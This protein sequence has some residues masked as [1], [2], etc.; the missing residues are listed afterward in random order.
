ML[1]QSSQRTCSNLTYSIQS[2]ND[3]EVMLFTVNTDGSKIEGYVDA[4]WSDS[5]RWKDHIDKIISHNLLVPAYVEVYFRPCPVGF[6]LS[7]D[8]SCV[9]AKALNDSVSGCFIDSFQIKRKNSYWIGVESSSNSSTSYLIHRHCPFDNC[10]SGTFLFSLEKPDAQCNQHH[11]GILCGACEPGYS[12]ILGGTECKRCTNIY[13]LLLIG[14]TVAGVG[15]IVFLS[16]TDTTVATGAFSGLLF[17]ANIIADNKTSFFPPQAA[18]SFLS[19]FIAWLNLDLGISTCFYDGLDA[20]V[21]TWLQL[22]FYVWL[23]AFIIIITCRHVS[24]MSKLCGNNIVPVLA[25]LFLLS[26]TQFYFERLTMPRLDKDLVLLFKPVVLIFFWYAVFSTIAPLSTGGVEGV[27]SLLHACNITIVKV[28][29][30]YTSV[31]SG[32]SPVPCS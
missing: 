31:H 18:N 23:L 20:Y 12:L 30:A 27:Q 19:V 29:F 4:L 32:P 9:C 22:P 21:Y 13:L 7:P 3:R 15:L 17:Y 10:K 28:H 1:V 16:L 25:T 14:F 6:E 2:P 8:Y 24:F 5:S 26:Y 11:S